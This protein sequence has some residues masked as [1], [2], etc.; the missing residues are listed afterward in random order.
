MKKISNYLCHIRKI[1]VP[2]ITEARINFV[3]SKLKECPVI[4]VKTFFAANKAYKKSI[5]C[6]ST[7]FYQT[8][9]IGMSA[10]DFNISC[11]RELSKKFEGYTVLSG[12]VFHDY[13]AH[14][15]SYIFLVAKDQ[16]GT[17]YLEKDIKVNRIPFRVNINVFDSHIM[18]ISADLLLDLDTSAF[19]HLYLHGTQC[20]K[21][22]NFNELMNMLLGEHITAIKELVKQKIENTKN[23]IKKL[24][25]LL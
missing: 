21:A 1:N 6:L 13:Y 7:A 23:S 5:L 8:E 20:P 18:E 9:C 24:E 2:S 25:S 11:G 15:H 4:D 12:K 22:R 17:F 16:A 14:Y 3:L 10:S 19:D